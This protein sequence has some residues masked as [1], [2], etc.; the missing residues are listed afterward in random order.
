MRVNRAIEDGRVLR[1][2]GAL[3]APSRGRGSAG[4]TSTCSASSPTAASTRTSTTCGR[5]SSSPRREDMAERTFV[6]AFTDGRDVSPT[7]AARD[8]AELVA[9]GAQIATCRGP[10]LRHGPRPALGADATARSPRSWQARGRRPDDP[11][12]A[13]EACYARG[14]TDEFVEPVVLPRAPAR[15]GG[16]GDLLQLPARPGAPALAAAPRA[17]AST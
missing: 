8:L 4:G 3:A 15:A 1:E 12:A 2:R 17:R 14:V 9:E 13:V 16:R 6:H 5:C 10:L 7:S 11:V